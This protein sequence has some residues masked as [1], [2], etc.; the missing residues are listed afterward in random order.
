MVSPGFQ[1][2]IRGTYS[3]AK[4]DMNQARRF[5]RQ[6]KRILPD[7]SRVRQWNW[8]V[9]LTTLG[10]ALF[11]LVVVLMHK[12]VYAI[13]MHQKEYRVPMD[14]LRTA[15]LDPWA[16]QVTRKVLKDVHGPPVNIMKQDALEEIQRRYESSP[17]VRRVNRVERRGH[18]SV[19]VKAELRRPAAAVSDRKGRWYLVDRYGVRLPGTYTS[20]PS[21]FGT[22]FRISGFAGSPPAPGEQWDA[23]PV[24]AASSL[25]YRLLNSG[26]HKKLEVTRI[27]INGSR[28]DWEK[29]RGELV[30]H[31][32]SNVQVVWGRAERQRGPWEPDAARKLRN[33]RLVLRGA[34]DLTGLEQVKLQYDDPVISLK[35]RR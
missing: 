14:R 35:S 30:F 4:R 18:E 20:P 16:D 13:L 17:W 31:T 19:K 12:K 26:I 5:L 24:P 6:G 29:G 28:N 11:S 15:K 21:S 7:V 2:D 8:H 27:E 1:F 34:P 9:I 3:V 32:R 10:V 25:A 33:L 23:R 22:V